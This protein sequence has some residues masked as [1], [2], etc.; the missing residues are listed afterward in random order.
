MKR[1]E[2]LLGVNYSF[3][4][5]NMYNAQTFTEQLFAKLK[6]SKH[7]FAVKTFMMNLVS[8]M[9]GRHRLILPQ[10]YPYLQKYLKYGNKEVGKIFAYLA[11]AVHVN[12][13]QSDLE[14]ILKFIIMNFANESCPDIKISMGLNCITQMCSRKP[15]VIEEEDLKFLCD[16]SKYKEKNVNRAIKCL[17]NLYRDLDP[18]MLPKQYRGR[19]D[20]NDK[21]EDLSVNL[22]GKRLFLEG[23]T[24]TTH[25]IEGV[26]LLGEDIDGKHIECE[27]ILTDEDFRK[28]RQLKKKEAYK[29]GLKKFA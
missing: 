2:E 17:I 6:A 24:Q 15:L 18:T 20:E 7:P 23:V 19:R 4:I 10:F 27:R 12:I 29:K 13:P 3:P 21:N 26:E 14:P 8:R 1:R 25:R 28:I 9:I 16:L 5:D 22:L 11:E